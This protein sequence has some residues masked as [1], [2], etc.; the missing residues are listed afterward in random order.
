M[1]HLS[2]DRLRELARAAASDAALAHDETVHLAACQTCQRTL[3]EERHL[4]RSLRSLAW[5][6]PSPSFVAATQARFLAAQRAREIRRYVWA[7]LVAAALMM[8]IT[9]S[10]AT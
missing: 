1:S 2:L 9:A 3:A 5:P 10:S 8:F 7:S 6:M 4:G